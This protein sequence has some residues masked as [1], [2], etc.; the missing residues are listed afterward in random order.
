M[1]FALYRSLGHTALRIAA[2]PRPGE[3]HRFI[4]F[5]LF[6]VG[7]GTPRDP[8]GRSRLLALEEVGQG[9]CWWGGVGGPYGGPLGELVLLL[10]WLWVVLLFWFVF[11]FCLLFLCLS[12]GLLLC[13]HLD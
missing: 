5:V 12:F 3:D 11:C 1:G 8:V 10:C 13:L 4:G 9:G 7:A 6:E 2:T